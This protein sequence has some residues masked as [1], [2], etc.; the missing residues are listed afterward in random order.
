M[1]AAEVN[2]GKATQA[3]QAAAVPVRVDPTH[4]APSTRNR[5]R[6]TVLQRQ[7]AA[8]RLHE[9][10]LTVRE[11]A[12]QLGLSVG[13]AHK[14]IARE[15]DARRREVAN[16]VLDL[17]LDRLDRLQVRHFAAAMNG[18]TRAADT[19]LRIMAR[20]A[21]YLGLDNRPKGDAAR[22]TTDLL[23]ALAA[24]LAQ[25]PDT[26]VS[27]YP[28]PFPAAPYGGSHDHHE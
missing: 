19:V 6:Q 18:D 23:G 21:K 25:A 5:S 2:T 14:A 27:A 9:A 17:E 15:N 10:G 8:L 26:Y 7:A 3:H 16:R 24:Q 13:G 1:T 20:R 11:V 12:A 4:S 28:A 22:T